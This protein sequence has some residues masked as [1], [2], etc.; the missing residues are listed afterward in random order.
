MK[1]IQ[2]KLEKAQSKCKHTAVDKQHVIEG[3]YI[4]GADYVK[5]ITYCTCRN[6]HKTWTVKGSI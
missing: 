1:K 2:A 3:E 4:A 5:D 6:C